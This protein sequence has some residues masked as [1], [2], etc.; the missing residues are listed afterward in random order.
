MKEVG[1]LMK[2]VLSLVASLVML[3]GIATTALA[4]DTVRFGNTTNVVS[5]MHDTVRFG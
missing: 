5:P 2:K 3:L 1:Y 4:H